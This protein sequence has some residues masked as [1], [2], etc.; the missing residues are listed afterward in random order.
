[1][2]FLTNPS[3][4]DFPGALYPLAPRSAFRLS[5]ESDLQRNN[6]RK[7]NFEKLVATILFISDL[8]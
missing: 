2:Y 6:T 5:G 1:M 3:G 4:P 8:L 7:Y